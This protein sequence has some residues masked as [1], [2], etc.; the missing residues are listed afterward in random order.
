MET[1]V[2]CGRT[3]NNPI[4]VINEFF[5]CCDINCMARYLND[6]VTYAD[7]SN[8]YNSNALYYIMRHHHGLCA[9]IK[10]CYN[11]LNDDYIL[12]ELKML[13]KHNDNKRTDILSIEEII[14]SFKAVFGLYKV[15][16][17]NYKLMRII[18]LA[19]CNYNEQFGAKLYKITTILT[20]M[21]YAASSINEYQNIKEQ[22]LKSN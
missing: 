13:E 2:W 14:A 22:L 15:G 16:K 9:L 11:I 6:M 5:E 3:I 12:N 17:W 10:A 7:S 19:M 21:I 18:K 8:C 20:K 1:K 4:E